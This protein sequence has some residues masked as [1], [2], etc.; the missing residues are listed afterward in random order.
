LLALPLVLLLAACGGGGGGASA[1][2]ASGGGANP[3]ATLSADQQIYESAELHGGT[4]SLLWSIPYGGGALVS[5]VDYFSAATTG[6]LAQSPAVAG[7]QIETP[8]VATLVDG[9]TVPYELPLRYLLGGQVYVRSATAQRQ[10][11]Y[12]GSQVQVDYLADDGQTVVE[13]ARFYG[14]SE[15][16]L[17]GAMGQAPEELQAAYPIAEWIGAN[18]FLPGATWAAGAAY[19]KRHGSVFGDTYFAEDCTNGPSNPVTIDAATTPCLSGAT[20][21]TLFPVTLYGSDGHPYETDF[22]GD[23][24]YQ[25]VQGLRMWVANAPAAADMDPTSA[26]RV[27]YELQGN[28]YMGTLWKDGT[29]FRYVQTDGSAVDYYLGLNRAASLSVQSGLVPGNVTPGSP[30]G[31]V[32]EVA[33]L[34]LFGIGGHG[35]NGALAPSDLLAHYG[36]PAGLDGAG[37]VIAVVD[38]PGSGAVADDLNVFSSFYG[39]PQCNSA[40]P[41]LQHIDLSDGAPVS[42]FDDWG[43]EAAMDTQLVHAIAPGATIVLVTAS[44]SATADLL[45]AANYAASLPGVIAV[46]MSFS[47]FDQDAAACLAE[48]RLLADFQA[49]RGTIF[50]AASGDGGAS[51]QGAGYPAASPYVTAVGGTR[52]QSVSWSAGSSAEVAWLYSGGGPS[53]YAAMP[54]WQRAL[55]G[56]AL[57]A[58]N[59]NMR[60]TP[61]VAAVADDQHS[62]VAVYYKQQW[63]MAGGTSVSTPLWAGMGA[64]FAQYLQ[65]KGA[66]LPQL[67]RATPGGFDGLLY[68]ARLSRGSAGVYHDIVSGS[69]DLGPAPCAICTASPGYDEVTGLGAPDLAALLA[70]F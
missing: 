54:A 27:F 3:S 25:V 8:V 18:S 64:L 19:T 24:T 45:A 53:S 7:A 26:Y 70:S 23:G 14:F 59:G 11:S 31:M 50:F 12:A 42:P 21:D 38:A 48:D 49:V 29:S 66:S 20:L 43:T 60:A 46:S 36:V 51:L 55:L 30:Q 17:S 2:S 4:Y 58:A 28:V 40:N 9:L 41:C 39:L 61:D 67:V 44:S 5:G 34:D 69:N 62:A 13:S 16:V 65:D 35:V 15:T 47:T 1:P 52:I 37:Q 22:A 6:G 68:Q 32:A 63:V 10:V 33:T 57:A 56:S